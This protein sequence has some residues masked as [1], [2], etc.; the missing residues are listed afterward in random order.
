LTCYT[1]DDGT[2][3]MKGRFTPE[4]GALICKA[5]DAAMEQLSEEQKKVVEDVSAETS[6]PSPRPTGT[7]GWIS[8]QKHRSR[9]GTAR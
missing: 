4:Q 3:V 7:T 9:H 6:L 8:P 1:D 5:L 2:W